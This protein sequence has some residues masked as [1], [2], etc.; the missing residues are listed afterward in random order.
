MCCAGARACSLKAKR[1]NLLVLKKKVDKT[2]ADLK[3]LQSVG[4]MIGEMLKQLDEDRFIVKASHGPRYIVGCRKKVRVRPSRRGCWAAGWAARPRRTSERGRRAHPAATRLPTRAHA[5]H[6]AAAA[7]RAQIDKSKLKA[8][9]R[10]TLDMTTFT[11]MRVLPREVD[12]T[13]YEML[14]EVRARHRG[15]CRTRRV[16]HACASCIVI[17]LQTRER[18]PSLNSTP[19][20]PPPP[21]CRTPGTCPSP[22]WAASTSRSASCARSS[23]CRSRSRSSSSAWGSSRPRCVCVL[24]RGDAWGGR[25][26]QATQRMLRVG[27]RRGAHWRQR[28]PITR[29]ADSRP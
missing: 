27:R 20:P 15:G 9:T 13:V 5:S 4:Q 21:P 24:P 11:I 7:R 18:A 1:E 14:H 6:P 16:R 19:P 23:S 22:P 26:D 10:V 28:S 3:A 29:T 2:E 25:G 8:G 12:P 17:A